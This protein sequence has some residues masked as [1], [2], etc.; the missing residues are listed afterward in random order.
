MKVCILL[1]ILFLFILPSSVIYSREGRMRTDVSEERIT[2]IFRVWNQVNKKPTWIRWLGLLVSCSVD[3]RLWIRRWY[4]SPKLQFPYWLHGATSQTMAVFITAAVRTSVQLF[5]C[6][7]IY[8]TKYKT[9]P[10]LCTFH[11]WHQ[12]NS[13]G[14]L[15]YRKLIF[16]QVLKSGTSFTESKTSLLALQESVTSPH[17]DP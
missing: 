12:S 9:L 15:I 4:V 2:L 7:E 16:F 11:D 5:I 13:I 17:S 6:F 8:I 10:W 3:F 14:Q 1:L